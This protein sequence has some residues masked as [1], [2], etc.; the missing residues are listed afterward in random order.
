MS[1]L[2]LEMA[3][4]SRDISACRVPSLKPSSFHCPSLGWGNSI[5]PPVQGCPPAPGHTTFPIFL[6][7]GLAGADLFLHPVWQVHFQHKLLNG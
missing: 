6:Q 7:Q 4:T 2:F 5:P 1:S 3:G